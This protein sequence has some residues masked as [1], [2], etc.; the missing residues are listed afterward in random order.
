MS[1]STLFPNQF[2]SGFKNVVE[3][4][5]TFYEL[6]NQAKRLR[7]ILQYEY[8]F[9]K[10]CESFDVDL[11][12]A[13]LKYSNDDLIQKVQVFIESNHPN[14]MFRDELIVCGIYF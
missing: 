1:V 13:L 7:D 3:L 14:S 10:Y 9:D 4:E 5:F 11:R 6:F 2:L 8:A 12:L